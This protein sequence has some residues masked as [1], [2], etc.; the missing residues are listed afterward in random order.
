MDTLTDIHHDLKKFKQN[1]ESYQQDLP[2]NP[3]GTDTN[4]DESSSEDE[5]YPDSM[6]Q[7]TFDSLSSKSSCSITTEANCDFDFYQSEL[8]VDLSRE[9]VKNFTTNDGN[10]IFVGNSPSK[11]YKLTP[12]VN[13]KLDSRSSNDLLNFKIKRSNSKRSLENLQAYV[14]ENQFG[15]LKSNSFVTLDDNDQ[16]DHETKL[17]NY[18][19]SLDSLEDFGRKTILEVNNDVNPRIYR[20]RINN[21]VQYG[22]SVP[23]FKKIFISD[24]IWRRNT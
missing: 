4:K 16:H 20:L 5:Y 7:N 24:Y 8:R 11:T 9:G 18:Q 23:D 3:M 21:N 10:I 1:P 12:K 13:K 17:R 2:K 14:D 15:M 6:N 22:G 19:K